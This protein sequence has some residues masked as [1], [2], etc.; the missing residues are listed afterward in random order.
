MLVTGS[1]YLLQ[2]PVLAVGA[3]LGARTVTMD[4]SLVGCAVLVGVE[5]TLLIPKKSWRGLPS[6][7]FL[8]VIEEIIARSL[9]V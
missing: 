2:L 4:C 5:D 8:Q 3:D 6:I 7:F 9:K 1:W